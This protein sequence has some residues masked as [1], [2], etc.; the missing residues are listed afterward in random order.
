LIVALYEARSGNAAVGRAFPRLEPVLSSNADPMNADH[1]TVD[2]I[3]VD[4]INAAH[5]GAIT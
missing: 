5:I 4:Q 3:I 1:V 2:Q